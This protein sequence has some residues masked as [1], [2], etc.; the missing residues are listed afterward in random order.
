MLSRFLT[1][2]KRTRN[3]AL[4]IINQ[5]LIDL[6]VLLNELSVLTQDFENMVRYYNN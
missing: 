1:N 5:S 4:I 3:H 6:E 2:S